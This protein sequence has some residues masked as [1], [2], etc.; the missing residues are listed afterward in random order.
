MH[1]H[2]K[3]RY[4]ETVSLCGVIVKKVYDGYSQWPRQDASQV[5]GAFHKVTCVECLRRLLIKK[6]DELSKIAERIGLLE[7]QRSKGEQN[8]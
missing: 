4:L 6:N 3:N 5:T 1:Y 7:Q 8:G 2:E